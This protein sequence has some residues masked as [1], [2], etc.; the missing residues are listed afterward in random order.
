MKIDIKNNA[1]ESILSNVVNG[2]FFTA[3]VDFT[4]YNPQLDTFKFTWFHT[5][6]PAGEVNTNWIKRSDPM[7]FKYQLFG[8]K[9][10]AR[11]SVPKQLDKLA[12][13]NYKYRAF[14]ASLDGSVFNAS[15][16]Y[17]WWP[18]T[19]NKFG[20]NDKSYKEKQKVKFPLLFKIKYFMKHL[21]FKFKKHG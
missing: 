21:T 18:N 13:G 6:G 20:V 16:N 7:V 10:F 15:V 12:N 3:S 11:T 2:A 19:I 14:S 17:S 8:W 9:E 5:A 4:K 1:R